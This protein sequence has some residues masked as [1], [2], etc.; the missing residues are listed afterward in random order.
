MPVLV[1]SAYLISHKWREFVGSTRFSVPNSFFR[2]GVDVVLSFTISIMFVLFYSLFVFLLL[3]K[4]RPW[5]KSFF[6]MHEPR[7]PHAVS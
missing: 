2:G 3:L 5:V 1:R 7:E 6:D 4:L